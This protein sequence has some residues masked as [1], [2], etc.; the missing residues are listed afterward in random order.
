M[1]VEFFTILSI[2][3]IKELLSKNTYYTHK[4]ILKEYGID[5]SSNNKVARLVP[6]Q[7]VIEPENIPENDQLQG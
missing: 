6:K 3:N 1:V 5:I 7:E 4:K 2:F